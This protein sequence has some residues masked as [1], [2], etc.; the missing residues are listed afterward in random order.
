MIFNTFLNFSNNIFANNN[1]K[2]ILAIPF[3]YVYI[4]MYEAG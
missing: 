1:D 4:Y 3:T 2:H